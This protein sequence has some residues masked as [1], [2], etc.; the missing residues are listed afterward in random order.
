MK[1][2]ISLESYPDGLGSMQEAQE[3]INSC[4]QFMKKG[5]LLMG[6][7]LNQV[8][9][10]E[11]HK[12]IGYSN[13]TDYLNSDDFGY[14]C[15][16]A[17]NWMN[18]YKEFKDFDFHLVEKAGIKKILVI[19]AVKDVQERQELI[20]KAPKMTVTEVENKVKE[21][22]RFTSNLDNNVTEGDSQVIKTRRIGQKLLEE[23]MELG[24]YLTSFKTQFNEDLK[25]IDE[26]L[27]KWLKFADCSDEEVEDIKG[28]L[29]VQL[30][31]LKEL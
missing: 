4:G 15:S 13:F 18:A 9:D 8:K 3:I 14:G 27:K 21:S 29:L 7:A 17:H 5:P 11:L 24:K 10:K 19:S 16:Q 30:N 28:K 2:I 25:N 31:E 22:K 1:D 26:G 20:E 23:S 6:W 12:Q